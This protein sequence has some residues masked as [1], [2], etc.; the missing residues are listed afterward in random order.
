[1]KEISF[2][3]IGGVVVTI[4]AEGA[5]AKG[6][7]VGMASKERVGVPA[8]NEGVCGVALDVARDGVA[9]VQ[10]RGFA[11]VAYSGSLQPGWV[12]LVANGSG[13]VQKAGTGVTG[14]EFLLVSSDPQS[15]T[16]V[17]LL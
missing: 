9:S 15:R 10:V 7:V 17:I 14:H 2:E 6:K 4:R 5:V 1:M 13:G 16:A 8:A 12:S 3:D 11:T